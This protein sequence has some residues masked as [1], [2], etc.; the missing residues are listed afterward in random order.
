MPL[1]DVPLPANTLA[2]FKELNKIAAFEF[3]EN[4]GDDINSLLRLE[5]TGPLNDG[6]EEL[7]FESVYVLN[8]VGTMT[9]YF[10]SYPVLLLLLMALKGCE[11]RN[12]LRVAKVQ[13]SLRKYLFYNSLITALL[14]GCSVISLSVLIGLQN[15]RFDSFGMTIQSAACIFFGV[16]LVVTP[17]LLFVRTL[18]SSKHLTE[19]EMESRY[20]SLYSNLRMKSGKGVLLQ[21]AF[22][23]LRRLMLS[24]AIVV[25][26]DNLSVQIFLVWS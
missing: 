13:R 12:N 20:G 3:Y 5:P 18:C 10:I 23:I 9:I 4:L 11:S 7:G 24:F 26:R 17:L 15:L 25:F 6:F 2:F 16:F 1:I 8:N 22:L 21:P 19:E 14:E